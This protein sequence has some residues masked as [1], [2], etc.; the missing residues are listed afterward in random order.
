M[1]LTPIL[2]DS[3][4]LRGRI[5]QRAVEG[6]KEAFP[7]KVR[8]NS[9]ELEDVK[10][11][12]KDYGPNDQKAALLEGST[13]HEPVKGTVVLRGPDGKELE[14]VKN[15]TLL[16][17][18]Y[19]TERHSFIV[20]GNEY[21]VANQ[22]RMKPGVYT[23][24][25]A[26]GELEAAFNTN[27]GGVNFKMILDPQKGHPYLEYKT[28][29][30]PLYPVLRS[31]GVSHD[32][33]AKHWGVEVAGQNA[34][35]FGKK[36][37]AAIDKLYKK[38]V[39]PAK[40]VAKTHDE[41]VAEIKKIYDTAGMDGEV[42]ESTLG[43]THDRVTPGAML[44]A[45]K[46]ILR[47]FKTGE[48]VDDRDSLAY[49]TFYSVDDFIK[50]RLKL[51]SRLLALKVKGRAT[52][53]TA[54]RDILPSQPFSS[55]V[56]AFLTG[57]KLSSIP[58]QIN[59][60]ELI[61][62]AVKVTSLGEGGIASERAIPLEARQLHPTHMGILDPIR[63]PE[64]FNAGVDIR[65]A[66]TTQRDEKGNLYTPLRNVKTGKFEDLSAKEISKTVVAFPGQKLEGMVGVMKN[67]QVQHV[68]ASE[69][70][71]EIF[72]SAQMYSPTTNLLPMMES[73]Q[74][75]RSTMGAKMQTQALPLVHR[76]QP[77]VQVGAHRLL[78]EPGGDKYE[79]KTTFE[80][81]VA[82]LTLPTSPVNG[83]VAKIDS[84][85]IYIDPHA[86]KTKEAADTL[87]APRYSKATQRKPE[88]QVDQSVLAQLGRQEM[89]ELG[90][91]RLFL[92]NGN[93]VRNLIDLDFVAGGNPC[94]YGYVP[95]GEL[96]AE[97]NLGMEIAPTF[98]HEFIESEMMLHDGM[99]YDKA[100][101]K[102]LVAEQL[103]RQAHPTATIDD[104]RA[105]LGV[106]AEKYAGAAKRQVTINGVTF[107]LELEPGD[108]REGVNKST[109]KAWRKLM[110]AAYGYIPKTRGDDDE[111]VDMYLKEDGFF[112][113][114]FVIHQNKADGTHDE[115]KCMVGFSNADEA[116]EC[117]NKHVPDWCFGSM[118]TLS[119]EEFKDYL[120]ERKKVAADK[121]LIKIPY[122]TNF[123]FAAKTYLH[124][125]VKV[126]EGDWVH[127]DQPLAES[128]FTKDGVLALGKNMKV[129]YIP[130]YGQN[131]NDA[132]VISEGAAVKLT[133]EHMYKEVLEIEPD[134]TVGRE[135][136][137]QF[138]GAKYT[139]DQYRKVSDSGVIKK[140]QKLLPHDP[141]IVGV[142]KG[143]PSA[144]D[145]ILGNIKKTLANPFKE[146]ITT[147]GHD[148]EGEVVDV[149]QSPK[150]IVVTVKTQEPMRVG[151]KLSGRYGNKGVVSEIVPDHRMIQD[152]S[153]KPVDILYTSAG[154][155]S[156]INPA[157]VMETAIS[158]VADKLGKPIVVENF[159]GRNN[160]EWAQEL[161][162]KH[163]VKDKETV[164]DP[165]SG[166][167]IPNVMVGKQFTL[168]L[169]KTTDT[170]YSAHGTG[171]Y[172]VN[173]QP[174]KGG[175][176]G[177]KAIG[178]MEFNALVAHNARNVLRE[179]AALKS[180]KNDEFW[181][182]VQLGLPLPPLRT[183]FVWDK[184]VGMLSGAGIKADKRGSHITLMPL[185]DADIKKMSSGAIENEKLVRAKDLHPERGGFFDLAITGGTQGTRW[186]HIDLAEPVVNPVFA[187]PVRRLLGLTV[188][189][190]EELHFDKGGAHIKRQLNAID[191]DAK[192][193]ELH[194]SL[195]N[196]S[197]AKLDDLIKQVKYLGALKK[198]NLKP[199]DAYVL[200]KLPVLPPIMRPVLP[201]KGGQEL[202]VGDANY[203]YPNAFLHNKVLKQ[204]NDN[205][206]LPPDEHKLL[207]SNLYNAI[208]A[209]IGTHESDNAKLQKR[210]VKG[211]LEHLTGK[212]TPKSSYF[213]QKLMKR[214][215]DVSGRGTIAP[216]GT[217]H[218]DEIGLP[219]EMLWE[220]FGKFIIARLVRRG[221]GAIQAKEMAENKH[222]AARDALLAEAKDRPVMV[223]RA[224][225]LHRYN[226]VS[227]YAVPVPG[228]TI[229]VNPFIEKGMNADYD[230]DTFQ[231]HAPATIEA[232]HD[233]KRMTL[234]NLVFGDRSRDQLMVE[235]A[236]EAVLGVHI[237]TQQKK[238][239]GKIHKFKTKEEALAA[240]KKGELNLHDQVEIG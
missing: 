94:R 197:G 46:K 70:Q 220:M 208:G 145:A 137:R 122:E 123:P 30:I 28:T 36:N 64:S 153:G 140:G 178:Q 225:S 44:D 133:S 164:F 160:V 68:P 9:I 166:K 191:I 118:D 170:N 4:V 234:S 114:V 75:N 181:R 47:A 5:R 1:S 162:K 10:V 144:T 147:W 82:K 148:F 59:P 158:K 77:L 96:W 55:G 63:T 146:V 216:A 97:S 204:Q 215:Q 143:K 38:V 32:D 39:H 24:R 149:F 65:T 121:D 223:N 87:S 76:E 51:D 98:L 141:M 56:R 78:G 180:Q 19:F 101:E 202:V 40:Q 179:A 184:F 161:L 195:K 228:K 52:S 142:K 155:I 177:S 224:P 154:I 187:D 80:S 226:F 211:F 86:K 116:L 151:D 113:Q 132:V 72:H 125:D 175:D 240:Y 88:H 112:S 66:L 198:Q 209:V 12:E 99:S 69:V 130:Y 176:E 111:T 57:S 22:I 11:H 34:D 135:I 33:I 218:M 37:E 190:F 90:N 230:G 60:I 134:M 169:F 3:P 196:T 103:F 93:V 31:L 23:R 79:Q 138:Y 207:R 233:A 139:A 150:R 108:Y 120:D 238:G 21:Q 17:L 129:A 14:R 45:S 104:V 62:H 106:R 119:W 2:I 100:H 182:A 222:P 27:K 67:G 174:T 15:F 49:K 54:L 232:V 81:W 203:L 84:Q 18:P 25:R 74:G 43:H 236:M 42:N 29:V 194:D 41:R 85:Y 213:Q 6:L 157:Q 71:Y 152:E 229:M 231:V 235:P 115:D 189:E 16:N 53:K 188:K 193:K 26:N 173:L 206:V 117:Y 110:H 124:Q 73:I 48:D 210:N 163:G 165:V 192:L 102:A 83:R 183:P 131:S 171:G 136:H 199:G 159:T 50:E 95:A 168:R 92:V 201:G 237:A 186:S 13:L 167:K 219:E 105:W 35:A 212:T 127:A 91:Y 20:D 107:K 89:G 214:P 61:D 185:T 109:G 126:K 8:D 239:D 7:L 205:P 227:A 221:F 128:N 172:D 58:T 200:S 217:L 156:R